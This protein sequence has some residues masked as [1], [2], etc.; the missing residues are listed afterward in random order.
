VPRAE[1]AVGQIPLGW[2]KALVFE[3]SSTGKELD[4]F[5]SAIVPGAY[6]MF[7][8]ISNQIYGKLRS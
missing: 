3:S 1:Y 6:C 8:R 5:V 4:R 2:T 7:L